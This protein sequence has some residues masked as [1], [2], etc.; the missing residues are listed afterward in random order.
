MMNQLSKKSI[1]CI[2]LHTH[3]YLPEYIKILK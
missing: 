2:D 1:K 3:L